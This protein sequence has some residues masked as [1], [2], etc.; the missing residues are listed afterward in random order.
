M[1]KLILLITFAISFSLG[2]QSTQDTIDK[3]FWQSMMFDRTVNIHKAK[4]A[5][6]LYFSNK[7]KIKGTGYKQFERWYHH[8]SMKVNPD[9]SFLAPNH[10]LNEYRK[11]RR[12][13]LT[14]RSGTGAWKNLGPFDDPFLVGEFVGVGRVNAIGFHPSDEKIIYAGAP[15]GGFWR[16]YDKGA[17]W[18]STTD[19]LPTLGVS[20]IAF[21]QNSATDSVILIGTGDRDAGDANGLGVM[22][23]TNGGVSFISSNT[24]IGNRT[25][26]MFAQN[27]LNKN[28]IFA[29]VDNGIYVSYNQGNNWIQRSS[30]G[31]FKDIKYCPSDTMTLY[32]TQ[33]GFF[34]RSTDAGNTWTSINTGFTATGRNRLAIAVTAANP[35]IVYVV[36]SNASTNGLESFYKSSNKGLSFTV[37]MGGAFNILGSN[38]NGSAAGGQGWYDL[39]ITGND[40]DSNMV[41]VGGVI[42]FRSDNGGTS[43]SAISHWFGGGAP[44]VHADVHYLARNPL[45]NE[46]YSGNDG[47]VYTTANNGTSWTIRNKGLAISQFYNFGVSQLSKTKFIT[48]AQDNGTSWGSDTASWQT[49]NFGG[50]GMQCEISN[51]DTTVMFG[52]VQYGSLRRTKNNGAS[53]Q[54]LAASI[55]GGPGPWA[56]PCHLHPRLNDIMVILYTQGIISK[57]IVSAANPTF[58]NFTTGVTGTGNALRFSNVNDSLVFM[59]WT[60]GNFRVANILASPIKVDSMSRPANNTIRDIETSFNNENVVYAACGNRIYRSLNKGAAWTD[61]SANLPNIPMFSIVLDKNSPEGLYVGTDAGVYYKDSLMANWIYYNT[62]LPINTEVR[63]LEIVY[64]TL[65]SSNSVIFAGTYG[66]GL[67]RGDLRVSETQPNPDFSIAAS[68]CTS[69]PVQITS[70]VT[71]I[72]NNG[73]STRYKWIIQPNTYSYQAGSTDTSINP[74]IIFNQSAK[75]TISLKVSKTYGGFCTIKKD[76]VI[77]VGTSGNL[78]LKSASDTTVCAGDSALVR[79][80]GM[81]NYSFQPA[82]GVNIFND[83]FAY[84][85]PTA[86][87]TYTIIGDNNGACHDTVYATINVRNYPTFTQSGLLKYCLGDSTLIQ[88]TGVDSA[89]WTP[90][91]SITNLSPTQQKVKVS[92][93]ANYTIRL[94]KAGMCD[95]KTTLPITVLNYANFNLSKKGVQEI[96]KGGVLSVSENNSIPIRVWSPTTNVTNA[97]INVFEFNPTVNTKYYLTTQDTNFCPASKDSIHINVLSLPNISISGPSIVCSGSTFQ[98]IALGGISYSWSPAT[99]LSAS[100]KDTVICSPGSSINYTITGSDGKCTNTATKSITVTTTSLKISYTGRTEACLGSGKLILYI[101]GADTLQWYPPNL[102]T[103]ENGDTVL[104]NS[105]KDTTL[106]V[107]GRTG[108]CRDSILIPIKIRPIPSVSILN[109]NQSPICAGESILIRTSGAKNYFLKPLYNATKLK[110]DSFRL[111]PLVTTKYLVFGANEY[112]CESMD[113]ISVIVNPLPSL[114]I[115][116]SIITMEK[117]DSLQII[118]SGGDSY[119]WS[120]T[121]YIKGSQ[122]SNKILV[123]PDSDIIYQV[124]VTSVDGC[125]SKGLAIIYVKQ[126]PNPPSAISST[127]L[128]QILVY[129]NPAKDFLTIETPELLVMKMY[130]IQGALVL[131]QTITEPKA[132]LDINHLASGNYTL[133]MEAGSKRKKISKIEIIK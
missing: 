37:R 85:K 32:A 119:L 42:Q 103:D 5:F 128:R 26:G 15:Q 74:V 94:V 54:G 117:G 58:A 24:G 61:I 20:A 112:G 51:F 50:D 82:I 129:P 1:K 69:I 70:N 132:R 29:A 56:A 27:P 46:L 80:G 115:S 133:L 101:K 109:K 124:E 53:W 25:V 6:D 78:T 90:S 19:D 105:D 52:N 33:N 9:G 86:N 38:T 130:N 60:N 45:N 10:T 73:L 75:Y 67:W 8:W 47:G 131:S 35:N 110:N 2:A 4:R 49:A 107:V 91:A 98:L 99:F 7:A 72:S 22:R 104:V 96:C 65:C 34:Y 111:A 55:P 89:F 95:V 59:G 68:A 116:P 121:K 126:D 118:A 23:S 44:F 62:G 30:A 108:T 92:T 63:D 102:V 123:K 41:A 16:T 28:T 21:I 100:N 76:S 79:L 106:K 36:A 113:S 120:P 83:S 64:D 81:Q 84:I 17:S 114:T 125:K 122:T 66:R 71:S 127:I 48:G 77:S 88:F 13:N 93:S 39:A 3:P 57:N 14:P 43:W 40:Q 97:G 87:Q 11:F 12:N 31:N 18:T